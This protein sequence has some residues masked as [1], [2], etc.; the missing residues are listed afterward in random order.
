[1]RWNFYF[2]EDDVIL[3]SIIRLMNEARRYA[4]IHK[5]DNLSSKFVSHKSN[6]LDVDTRL[7]L[8]RRKLDLFSRELRFPRVRW[9]VSN[10]LKVFQVSAPH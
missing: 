8:I 10:F 1:M 9:F 3:H 2:I 5:F 7:E 4:S 6:R